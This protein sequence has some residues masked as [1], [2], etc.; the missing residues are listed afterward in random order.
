MKL[1]VKDIY[2]SFSDN[3]ILHGISLSVE[4]G[5]ALGLLGRNGAGKTTTIR[6]LMNLFDADSGE[7]LING[8]NFR[9]LDHQI[10]YLPEERGLYPKKKVIEQLIYLG[11]LRGLSKKEAKE[12]SLHWLKR[13]GVEEYKDKKLETLSKGN[14]QK[15]Q[16][17]Q[18]FLCNPDIII[19]DEPFSGLD[20][21]N[22]QILKDI[23]RE[24]IRENKLLI[25]SSHQ[26][27]YVEEFCEEIAII[28]FGEIVL[29]GNLKEIKSIFG[30]N[31]LTLSIVN[32][33][34]EH[35]QIIFKEQL[36]HIA[37]VESIRKNDVII[38]LLPTKTKNDLLSAIL[39]M[40]LDIDKFT[41]YEPTLE[42]I[43]VKKVGENN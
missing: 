23:I 34:P 18:T 33:A 25:F 2:K 31:R 30:Q 12:N 27:G 37:I 3:E 9:A 28:N 39:S 4:S 13:L 41:V 36:N 35:L 15:V 24:L 32:L 6:I 19:L 7:I 10:G 42:D 43:F 14:Q 26:M 21:L 20:P 8:Q 1:E 22:S 11:Q 17:A 5:K 29:D 16:L 40:D 38:E